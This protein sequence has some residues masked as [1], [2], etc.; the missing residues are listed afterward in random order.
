VAGTK[1][2]P[3]YLQGSTSISS[4]IRRHQNQRPIAPVLRPL[5]MLLS[6]SFSGGGSGSQNLVICR[7]VLGSE[8]QNRLSETREPNT[9]GMKR[10]TAK[11]KNHNDVYHRIFRKNNG[12]SGMGGKG[13]TVSREDR[14]KNQRPQQARFTSSP[15]KLSCNIAFRSVAGWRSKDKPQHFAH[16]RNGIYVDE[17]R[18]TCVVGLRDRAHGRN[19]PWS[20]D[21]TRNRRPAALLVAWAVL[22][23]FDT[24]SNYGF[25]NPSYSVL[26]FELPNSYDACVSSIGLLKSI[27]D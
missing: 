19:W 11:L 24:G 25:V 10:A 4:Q 7:V 14:R 16:Q 1:L 23:I 22:H 8:I 3:T 2:T 13:L 9:T 6:E 17:L 5:N 26:H 15:F 27:T 21:I 12:S 18:R 20:D